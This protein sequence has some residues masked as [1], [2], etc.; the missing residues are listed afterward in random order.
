LIVALELSIRILERALLDGDVGSLHHYVVT[1]GNFF[2]CQPGAKVVQ[3]ERY[4]NTSYSI[5]SHGFRGKEIEVRS[6]G[7]KVLFLGDSIA[8]G[9]YVDHKFTYPMLLEEMHNKK[10]PDRYPIK[11]V[12]LAIFAY[13]PRQ[14]LQA[15][16]RTGLKFRPELIVL[17]L[18]MNDFQPRVQSAPSRIEVLWQ[19]LFVLKEQLV[20]R[21][22]LLRRG[23]QALQMLTYN[24]VHD[25]RRKHFVNTLNDDEPRR[26]AEMFRQ[27]SDKEIEGF[28]EVEQIHLRSRAA[29][30]PLVAMLIPNEVQLTSDKFDIINERVKDFCRR[31]GIP[32]VDPLA[33]MR[34]FDRKL[35]L[36][37]DG[38]HLSVAGHR[39]VAEWLLPLLFQGE[40]SGIPRKL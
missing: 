19:R 26:K 38:S 1:D 8:F 36:F 37:C 9:L 18:Y 16:E 7:R 6:S 34:A 23:R 40:L 27:L 24:L 39:F 31:K 29:S 28:S 11:S 5:N 32:F 22:A 21:I 4:G 14:E 3:P 25:Q 30:V 35:I 20:F 15:L 17:Q 10:F 12:N 2:Y 13:T 33:S